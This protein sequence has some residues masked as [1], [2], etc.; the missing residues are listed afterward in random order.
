MVPI[1]RQIQPVGYGMRGTLRNA[2][3][4]SRKS[5]D[6]GLSFNASQ[7]NNLRYARGFLHLDYSIWPRRVVQGKGKCSQLDYLQHFSLP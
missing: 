3:Q 1:S 6:S 5:V 7:A 4:F 2:M